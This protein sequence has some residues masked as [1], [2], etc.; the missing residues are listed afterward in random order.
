MVLSVGYLKSFSF[1]YAF[2]SSS[3]GVMSFLYFS[4]SM[5]TVVMSSVCCWNLM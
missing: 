2:I 1:Q 4:M 5:A 3:V